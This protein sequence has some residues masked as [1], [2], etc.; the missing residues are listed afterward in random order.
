MF[1]NF[2]VIPI[3]IFVRQCASFEET[4]HMDIVLS[5]S[6]HFCLTIETALMCFATVFAVG[7]RFPSVY[8]C[9]ASMMFPFLAS[10][11]GLG[12]LSLMLLERDG[13]CES[14]LAMLALHPC[15]I[16]I[17]PEVCDR[18]ALVADSACADRGETVFRHH[19][20]FEKTFSGRASRNE[21]V[22]RGSLVCLRYTEIAPILGKSLTYLTVRMIPRS[23]YEMKRSTG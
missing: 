16:D 15:L 7:I 1:H 13:V 10:C 17:E 19:E 12:N 4:F 18:E 21:R 6:M 2:L 20:V 8:S 11:T 3:T 14:F 22:V 5:M 9:F 23:K